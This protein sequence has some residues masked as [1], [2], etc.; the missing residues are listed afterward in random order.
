MI[1]PSRMASRPRIESKVMSR[2]EELERA[3]E[4]H[5]SVET[6]V[7]HCEDAQRDTLNE[8]VDRAETSFREGRFTRWDEVK[9]RNGL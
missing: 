5:K 9:R 6:F 3:I 8:Q 2:V 1:N 4:E 7:E